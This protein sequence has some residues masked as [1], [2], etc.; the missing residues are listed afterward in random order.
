MKPFSKQDL[1][2]IIATA[3]P[4]EERLRLVKGFLPGDT[5]TNE[6]VVKARLDA[7]CQAVAK[8]DWEL[9]HRRLTYDG[10]DEDKVRPFL[11]AGR[12]PEDL[13]LPAWAETLNEAVNLI[14]NLPLHEAEP[15]QIEERRLA[16]LDT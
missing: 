8:G 12:L 13:K 6:K 16:C 5:Q 7:W 9:F 2:N 4:F 3:S 1:L 11:G 15:G 10:L 14:A